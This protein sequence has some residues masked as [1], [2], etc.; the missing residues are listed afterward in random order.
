MNCNQ[1][2]DN[3]WSQGGSNHRENW[4]QNMSK[5]KNWKYVGP[6]N[7]APETITKENV[8]Y[9]WCNICRRWLYGYRAHKTYYMSSKMEIIK[10]ETHTK[11]TQEG[12]LLV[13]I[14]LQ[15]QHLEAQD[16]MEIQQE[17][18]LDP[19]GCSYVVISF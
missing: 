4:N 3:S 14:I 9:T 16:R 10:V 17:V 13:E 19:V 1:P 6:K 18:K 12:K 11:I 5:V 8:K 7:G 15:I 2:R